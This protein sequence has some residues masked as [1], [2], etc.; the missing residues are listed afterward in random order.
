MYEMAPKYY[1]IKQKLIEMINSEEIGPDGQMPSEREI[2]NM[3]DVSRITARKAI[4]DLV[5]EGY[6][7]RIQ[8]KGTF[9]KTDEHSQDLISLMSCTEDIRRMGMT[10]SKKLIEAKVIPADK[11]RIR[12]LQLM[13]GDKV[14]MLKRVYCADNEPLN[15]TT[16]YL[17]IKLFPGIEK[18]DFGKESVYSVLENNY[19]VEITSATRTIEAVLALD[20]V[21]DVLNIQPGEPLLL[22]RAVTMGKVN[23]RQVPIET[24]KSFYRTDKFKFF[25]NQVR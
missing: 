19:K 2:M 21:A 24:F 25:I 23:G 9:V 15:Y 18:N 14:L 17:P 11:V 5:N 20:D 10:P 22:F 7:Y 3:F 12:K 6:L 8:G 1:I 16:T 13:D 4:D